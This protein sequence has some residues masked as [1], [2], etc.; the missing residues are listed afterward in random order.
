MVG[1]AA[2]EGLI[3]PPTPTRCYSIY[4]FRV[5]N[6]PAVIRME[7]PWTQ[8]SAPPIEISLFLVYKW[9]ICA[10]RIP[11]YVSISGLYLLI[12]PINRA[13]TKSDNLKKNDHAYEYMGR[14]QITDLVN[15]ELR[16]FTV[17]SRQL[18]APMM[19]LGGMVWTIYR[20]ILPPN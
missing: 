13:W 7:R 10:D 5:L 2:I 18:L 3:P 15:L 17:A 20:G 14:A 8:R 4:R 11:P 1:G 9:C 6:V 19:L 12:E 16:I